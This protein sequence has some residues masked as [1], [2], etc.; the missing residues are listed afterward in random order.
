MNTVTIDDSFE[1]GRL[2][3]LKNG[4]IFRAE[5]SSLAEANIFIKTEGGA[6][7]LIDGR[8]FT[9]LDMSRWR[10]AEIVTKRLTVQ[11]GRPG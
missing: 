11:P 7:S 6:L 8:Y 5:S 4:T 9:N 3:H 1:Q 10:T 2:Q